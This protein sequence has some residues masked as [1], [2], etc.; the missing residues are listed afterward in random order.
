MLTAIYVAI[1]RGRVVF[2]R[3]SLIIVVLSLRNMSEFETF[4]RGGQQLE[5]IVRPAYYLKL[6]QV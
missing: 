4:R 3:A 2:A 1:S 6:D 5:A